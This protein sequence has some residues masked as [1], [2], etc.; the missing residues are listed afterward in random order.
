MAPTFGDSAKGNRLLDKHLRSVGPLWDWRRRVEKAKLAQPV[1][2]TLPSLTAIRTNSAKLGRRKH[3]EL[4]ETELVT[5]FDDEK[6]RTQYAKAI[7]Q[8]L[9]RNNREAEDLTCSVR[10]EMERLAATPESR[11][12]ENTA[13]TL[14]GC[15]VFLDK[16]HDSRH[17]DETK[18]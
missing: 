15:L 18:A 5:D 13:K 8:E 9:G 3:P 7:D 6:G 14:R 4:S 12:A 1:P 17:D 2:A 16:T 10:D 11:T